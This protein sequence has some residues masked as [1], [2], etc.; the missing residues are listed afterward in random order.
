MEPRYTRMSATEL[1]EGLH[2][3]KC[4][5]KDVYRRL[6]KLMATGALMSIGLDDA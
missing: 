3:A 5:A 6:Q 4:P 1:L 2:H